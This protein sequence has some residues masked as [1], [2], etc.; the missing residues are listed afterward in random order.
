MERTKS[1]VRAGLTVGG[2]IVRHECQTRS[3]ANKNLNS[4]LLESKRV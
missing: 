2:A 1:R 3:K 4:G